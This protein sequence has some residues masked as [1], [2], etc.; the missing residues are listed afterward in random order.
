VSVSQRNYIARL[1]LGLMVAAGPVSAQSVQP[2]DTQPP[3]TV[4]GLVQAWMTASENDSVDTFRFRRLEVALS[5]HRPQRAQFTLMVDL[6]RAID[7]LS[8]LQDAFVTLPL[9]QHL[10]I[11][12]GRFVV[13]LGREGTEGAADQELLERSLFLTDGARHG[14]FGD[15]RDIGA[16]VDA[17]LGAVRMQGGYF[18]GESL[19]EAGRAP[20]AV[21]RISWQLPHLAAVNVG[22][23]GAIDAGPDDAARSA[24]RKGVDMKIVRPDWTLKSEL[25]SGED[26]G[27]A[28]L[29]YAML[30]E[31]R[32][33]RVLRV[34]ARAESWDPDTAWERDAED[35][36]ERAV[37]AGMTWA[38]RD[39]HALQLQANYVRRWF[40]VH[41]PSTNELRLGLQARW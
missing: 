15:V 28:R 34:A 7:D 32:L 9:R 35:G 37:T 8:P 25:M 40:D 20:V 30:I 2:S 26:D 6:A 10:S 24:S 16:M 36:R 14:R 41:A 4:S 38:F 3:V 29:G 12:A 22:A 13:P 33:S 31:R 27:V 18:R 23:S 17:G 19:F 1:A 5:A 11:R 21:G 39:A